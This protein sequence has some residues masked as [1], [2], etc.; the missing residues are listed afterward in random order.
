MFFW[1]A[2]QPPNCSTDAITV[3]ST[4][5]N[6][7]FG[8]CSFDKGTTR[9]DVIYNNVPN[10]HDNLQGNFSL[11]DLTPGQK[12][13]FNMLAYGHNGKPSSPLSFSQY[14]RKI[15]VYNSVVLSLLS[16]LYYSPLCNAQEKID[17][18]KEEESIELRN[19]SVPKSTA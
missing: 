15:Y 8:R 2:L 13:K 7:N 10:S 12:M 3:Y 18:K 4:E 14:T 1:I 9:A 19:E 6:I 17:L 16:S 11:I 5:I